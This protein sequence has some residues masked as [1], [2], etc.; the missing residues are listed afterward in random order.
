MIQHFR[1]Q[2]MYKD[3]RLPGW[4]FS[5]YYN[6]NR[7]EGNYLKEGAIEWTSIA[8]PADSLQNVT[9]QIHELMLYHVY[10]NQ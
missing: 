6:R 10:D 4:T 3:Q 7:Y 1:Y 9:S 2:S 5:F 8:P